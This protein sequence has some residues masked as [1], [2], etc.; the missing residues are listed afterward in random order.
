MG[1]PR[2]PFPGW[3]PDPSGAPGLRYWDGRTWWLPGHSPAQQAAVIAAKKT[4]RNT[5]GVLVALVAVV[6]GVPLLLIAGIA[7]LMSVNAANMEESPPAPPPVSSTLAPTTD[8][9]SAPSIPTLFPRPD[10]PTV[11]VPTP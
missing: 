1:G 2:V 7:L 10:A 5:V 4:E 11:I 6:I 8:Q 9:T 3:Y